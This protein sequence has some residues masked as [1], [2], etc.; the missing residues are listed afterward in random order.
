MLRATL[1]LLA[2]A[3]LSPA[4]TIQTIYLQ[5]GL[6]NQVNSDQTDVFGATLPVSLSFDG[7]TLTANL[8]TNASGTGPYTAPTPF[9]LT[10]TDLTLSCVGSSCGAASVY[11]FANFDDVAGFETPQDWTLTLNGS[12]P[13]GNYTLYYDDSAANEFSG[14]GGELVLG[15]ALNFSKSG[16][17]SVNGSFSFYGQFDTPLLSNGDVISFPDSFDIQYGA[18]VPEPATIT[19]GLGGL[20]LVVLA[21][22]RRRRV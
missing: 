3:V 22:A 8:L 14:K 18:A 11:F 10:L 1:V 16:A 13:I 9:H 21:R 20:L 5:V 17:F 12:G 15:P 4:A 6:S 7:L 19:A 2:A